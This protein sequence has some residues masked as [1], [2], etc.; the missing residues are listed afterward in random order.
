MFFLFLLFRGGCVVFC[1][2]RIV[3][4][5]CR[6]FRLDIF[7]SVFLFLR[8]SILCVLILLFRVLCI[9]FLVGLCLVGWGLLVRLLLFLLIW[10][11]RVLLGLVC[12][13]CCFLV[14]LGFR[15]LV[16]LLLFGL[17]L[18]C[19]FFLLGFLVCSLRLRAMKRSLR[20]FVSCCRLWFLW[21]FVCFCSFVGMFLG[22]VW[23]C[24]RFFCLVLLVVFLLWFCSILLFFLS[25][26]LRFLRI[27][28]VLVV[29]RYLRVLC[30][31][32][33]L[34]VKVLVL[35]LVF[36]LGLGI[37]FGWVW[38]SFVFVCFLLFGFL[39][40]FCHSIYLFLCDG[41]FFVFV[42]LFW[43]VFLFFL[44]ILGVGVCFFWWYFGIFFMFGDMWWVFSC[45]C[46]CFGMYVVV[47]GLV[48]RCNLW[49]FW[50]MVCLFLCFF[51]WCVEFFVV[52]LRILLVFLG[53]LASVFLWM[54]VVFLFFWGQYC[55]CRV[56]LSLN[57]QNTLY[58]SLYRY[59]GCVKLGNLIFNEL[60][61]EE[62][63]LCQLK[64][65]EIVIFFWEE[66]T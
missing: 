25:I 58:T 18:F 55:F 42:F 41:L 16:F 12:C 33:V 57:K 2:I 32:R 7:V 52:Y 64:K 65:I 29:F 17:F 34:F 30:C 53:L 39:S 11:V 23:W 59:I 28:I 63:Y 6:F 43:C 66:N 56:K 54:V 49:V 20:I 44:L 14:F 15:R 47:G 35:F 61:L 46:L 19:V 38:V 31:F 8:W 21:C 48:F 37:G 26:L 5:C 13:L 40:L 22:L 27:G 51:V 9:L 62:F 3:R 1:V 60:S 36:V 24:F 50:I 45:F 4:G 10:V